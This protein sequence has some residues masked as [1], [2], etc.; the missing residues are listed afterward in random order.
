LVSKNPLVRFILS[1]FLKS[2]WFP[3]EQLKITLEAGF[4]A[5]FIEYVLGMSKTLHSILGTS[6]HGGSLKGSKV[7]GLGLMVVQRQP[8]LE[9]LSP[10]QLKVI[11]KSKANLKSDE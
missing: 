3:L 9:T 7:Q 1:Y 4:A 11:F 8:G 2:F 6:E 5:Q 10:K